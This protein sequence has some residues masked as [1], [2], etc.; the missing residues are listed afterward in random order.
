MAK[1]T[2][3]TPEAE[4]KKELE[5]GKLVLG[6]ENVI[7]GLRGGKLRKV[8]YASISPASIIER[9]DRYCGLDDIE[10]ASLNLSGEDIGILCR[11][12]FSISVLGILKG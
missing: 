6:L 5:G 4:I 2:E 12:P 8:Y 11:K 1:G 9:L 7:K 3:M 10:H